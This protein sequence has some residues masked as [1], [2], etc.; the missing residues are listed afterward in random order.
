VAVRKVSSRLGV[1]SSFSPI[2]LHDL[3]HAIGD[4]FKSYVS[5]FLLRAPHCVSCT[6][7][8]GFLFVF[9]SFFFSSFVPLTGVFPLF[10]YL[11]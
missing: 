5:Y 4:V 6:L 9:W 1:L 7:R 2:S 11:Q 3:L 8:C 10:I